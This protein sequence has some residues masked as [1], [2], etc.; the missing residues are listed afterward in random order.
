MSAGLSR[1]CYTHHIHIRTDSIST[2]NVSGH[3]RNYDKNSGNLIINALKPMYHNSLQLPCLPSD[4]YTY[5]VLVSGIN[6]CANLTDI[7]STANE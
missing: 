7:H 4:I 1:R 3:A 5:I 6:D 2:V